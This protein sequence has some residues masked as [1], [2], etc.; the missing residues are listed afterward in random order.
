LTE[1]IY[2]VTFVA[3]TITTTEGG[4]VKGLLDNYVESMV[5]YAVAPGSAF[6][7]LW[8]L[9]RNRIEHRKIQAKQRAGAKQWG[10]EIGWSAVAQAT[11]AVVA[12][13]VGAT[14][15]KVFGGPI[16]L[17]SANSA[18][19]IAALTA[20]FIAF[21]DTYFY[22]THRAL[23][24]KALYRRFHLVHH[25]SVDVTPLTSFSFHPGEEIIGSAPFM[26]ATAMVG[27]EPV[28]LLLWSLASLAN[29]IAGHSGFEWAPSWWTT[30]PILRA[31]TPSLHH[32]MHHEK[33]RG[34]YG[35]YFT[36]W[37]RLCKTEFKDYA[38]RGR[39]LRQR[40][41]GGRLPRAK[42]NSIPQPA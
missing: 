29:N 23:H 4:S 38:E 14:I 37:D 8:L 33:V 1:L 35:L 36:F 15:N 9:L 31:K 22:W 39:A 28:V 32:N 7:A 17:V 24:T 3:V 20:M 19:S 16:V 42:A 34:N 5:V 21:D 2:F 18:L 26:I 25:R 11:S 30:T 13:G 27:F 12:V 40:I 6:V 41:A 10:R